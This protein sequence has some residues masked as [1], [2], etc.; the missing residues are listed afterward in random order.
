MQR[1]QIQELLLFEFEV[2]YNTTEANRNI[3][4]V[5]GEGGVD[6]SIEN[7]WLKKFRSGFKNLDD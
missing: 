5:K 2:G 3:C 7:K 1:N 4:C 6:G